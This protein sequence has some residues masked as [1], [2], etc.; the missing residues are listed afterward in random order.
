MPAK[1]PTSYAE[2]AE[3]AM[4]Q[5]GLFQQSPEQAIEAIEDA[6]DRGEITLAEFCQLM[7]DLHQ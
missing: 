1:F 6:L 5:A 2:F 3:T 4:F 7:Q